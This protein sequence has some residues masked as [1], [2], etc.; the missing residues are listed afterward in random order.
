M[1]RISFIIVGF[2]SNILMCYSQSAFFNLAKQYATEGNYEEAIRLT[3]QC[4]DWD[5]KIPDKLDLF[6]DYEALCDYYSQIIEP[7]SCR[8]YAD[9]AL[10]IFDDVDGLEPLTAL[11]LLSGHLLKAG[12]FERALDCRKQI[13]DITQSTYGSDSPQ[14]VNE[15]CMLSWFYQNAGN[16]LLAVEY[17]K[18]EEE[19]AYKTR[20]VIMS[21][22]YRR[23]YE[24]SF[25]SLMSV[26]Q[27]CDE[28]IA[29]IQYI[30]KI[31]N[32][33]RDAI[34]S[35]SRL[36]ALNSIWAISRDNNFLDGCL[37]VYKENALY[38]TY[39]EKLTNLI[40]INVEDLNIKND[41]HAAEY[42]Q[43]LYDIVIK[44]EL[45][46]WFSEEE[47]E[48]LLWLLPDYYGKIGLVRESFEM[49]KKN[50]EWRKK[51][52]KELFFCDVRVL[53]SGSAL[54]EEAAYVADF[55]EKLIKGHRYDND[56]EV[57]RM[58]YENLAGAYLRLGNNDNANFYINK[59]G[60]SDEYQSLYAKAGVYLQSGDMK[61]LLPIS[62]KLNEF[63]DVQEDNRGNVLLMLLMSARNAREDSII[64]KYAN[65]YVN[66]YRDYLLH[67]IPLM[68]EEEQAKYIRKIPFSN[69]LSYDFFIGINDNNNIEWSAAKDAYNYSLL[70]KGILLTSQT[71][72]RAEITNSTDSLIQ[73]QWRML[74]NSGSNYLLHD[75][76]AKRNL[77]NYASHKSCYLNRL[78]YTWEDVKN[79]LHDDEA[80]IE[81]IMCY[82]FHDFTD[83]ECNPTY[84]ALIIRKDSNEPITV[85]LSSV[86]NFANLSPN[87]LLSSN[88][89]L[90]Y[91]LLWQP[92]ESYL[93][94]ITRVYFSPVEDLNSIPI[95]Y[96]SMGSGRICDKWELFRVSSTR[97]II[98]QANV[99]RR[100]SAVLFGGLQYDLQKD[101]LVAIS[102]RGAYHSSNATRAICSDDLR[103]KVKYLPGSLSEVTDIAELFAFSPYLVTDT[104]GTEESFKS[105]DGSSYDIIHL[106]THGFFWSESDVS[107]HDNIGFLHDEYFQSLSKE[108]NAMLRS[109]LVFS[110][111]SVFLDGG[112]LPDDVEDGI[113]T[114]SELST[115]NLGKI[116]LVVLSA[117]DS[118]LGEISSEGVFGLQRGFKLAGAKSLLMSLWKV[119]DQATYLLMTEFY[120]QYLSGRSKRQSLYLAQSILRESEEFS[121]PYYWASFILLD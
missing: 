28:P 56:E 14:L 41:V 29:G 121:E 96:V 6:L 70:K 84:I 101:E 36:R 64:Q 110:G 74:Q 79:A 55:G 103:Y 23:T 40:N 77:I 120:R 19:L 35:E 81:F 21:F 8:H 9:L 10:N 113:L 118:G 109:G 30:I 105:L 59:I 95:E 62:I 119:D 90:L 7:D 112:E 2:I 107:K 76:I 39:Q 45:A 43:S 67:N 91:N 89:K 73:S 20:N 52:N 66:T 22:P 49:A 111:A 11:E 100:D 82:N 44:D 94:G 33:H 69:L 63:K 46:Q 108:D 37:A 5:T 83:K 60:E 12:C 38:G 87:E 48:S 16:N 72:F 15:Y 92:L 85:A 61:S 34:N 65:E 13:F 24:E 25:S 75:E 86:S 4:L 31:L 17:A 104:I 93:Q 58:I 71:E 50:Y 114:A 117:C 99:D 42:A 78:S 116:N 98:D 106:A 27:K 18:K 115:L 26:I 3:K 47:I 80:A 68:S 102:R 51:N 88:N 97:E 32:E 53:I 57:L 1:K 54:S